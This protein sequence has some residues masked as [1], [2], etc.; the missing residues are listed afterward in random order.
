MCLAQGHNAV[1]PVNNQIILTNYDE[2]KKMSVMDRQPEP[3]CVLPK[4]SISSNTLMKVLG[5]DLVRGVTHQL[6]IKEENIL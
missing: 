4:T 2:T 1:T 3:L 6:S 5:Q